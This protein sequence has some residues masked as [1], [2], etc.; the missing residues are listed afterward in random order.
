MT[1]AK[2]PVQAATPEALALAQ[3]LL[4]AHHAAL[5]YMDPNTAT[6]AISRI[7]FGRVGGDMVTL[8]SN[9]SAH[10]GGLQANADCA[11]MLGEPGGKGDPLTHPRLMLQARA[12]FVP[13]GSPDHGMLREG[14]LRHQPKAKLYI[15]FGD[16][17]FVRF[18]PISAML[19][20]GFGKAFRLGPVELRG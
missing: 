7:A 1:K 18:E 3:A 14:W 19:N 15:D 10:W 11:L 8:I 9:L 13:Q 2:D 12:N 5:G 4:A 17:A 20:G 6:P 16:F